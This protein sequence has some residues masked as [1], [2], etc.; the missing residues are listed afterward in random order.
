MASKIKKETYSIGEV[1]K[2]LELPLYTIRYYC[3]V[4]NVNME[5]TEGKHRRFTAAQVSELNEIKNIRKMSW[6]DI[7]KIIQKYKRLKFKTDE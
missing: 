1:S 3:E 4:H 6:P 5:T 7:I 2:E